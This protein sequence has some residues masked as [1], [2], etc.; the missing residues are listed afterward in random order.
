MPDGVDAAELART[1]LSQNLILA[2]GNV[3]SPAQ[4]ASGFM[5]FNVAHMSDPRV[6]EALAKTLGEQAS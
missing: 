3:F 4:S 2:P 6:F 1:A 5:R